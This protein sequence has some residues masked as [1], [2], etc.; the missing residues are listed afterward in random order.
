VLGVLTGGLLL[1][2]HW[3]IA[4]WPPV[5]GA[6]APGAPAALATAAHLAEPAAFLVLGILVPPV[7]GAVE[8]ALRAGAWVVLGGPCVGR[9]FALGAG[10]LVIG[11]AAD[12]DIPLCRDG[13]LAPR[14]AALTCVQGRYTIHD[15]HSQPTVRVNGRPVL[16]CPLVDGDQIDLGATTVEH[17]QRR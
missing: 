15:L 8:R 2:A 14:H 11:R 3:I 16:A 13:L 1:G 6:Q 4:S 17:V 10:E 5:G 9:E 7:T 12:C